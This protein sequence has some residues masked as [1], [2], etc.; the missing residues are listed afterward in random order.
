[1]SGVSA[2]TVHELRGQ[3]VSPPPRV[4]RLPTDPGLAWLVDGQRFELADHDR[5]FPDRG[6]AV[7]NNSGLDWQDGQVVSVQLV[8]AAPPVPA[9][10]AAGAVLLA[11][12]LLVRGWRPARPS[13]GRGRSLG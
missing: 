2:A 4:S 9:L 10:P 8:Q 12:V 1:M 6:V 3:P 7:W 13:P 11:L 5:S